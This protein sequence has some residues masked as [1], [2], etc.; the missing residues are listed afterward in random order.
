M[1]YVLN[2]KCVWLSLFSMMAAAARVLFRLTRLESFAQIR[3]SLFTVPPTQ[4][5]PALRPMRNAGSNLYQ[6]E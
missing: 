3:Q 6:H 4:H 1:L 2:A 5:S